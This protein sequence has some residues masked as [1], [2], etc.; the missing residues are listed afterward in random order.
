M[1]IAD[2]LITVAE[3]VPKVYDA[4]KKAEYDAF[5][6]AYQQ[7]G[8]RTD[9][10]R[11]FCGS[12]WTAETLKPKYDINPT[13]G[14]GTAIF[15]GC[16]FVGN[17][18]KH[19]ETL[20]IKLDFSRLVTLSQAFYQAYYITEL[21]DIDISNCI[22][23]CAYLF[24]QC[25]ALTSVKIIIS[26]NVAINTNS[27]TG[28]S[29]LKELRFDGT[30]GQSLDLHWSTKLSADS[31]ASIIGCLSP[32]ATNVTLTISET[33]RETFKAK[34][35]ADTWNAFLKAWSNWTIAYA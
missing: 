2:K 13:F 27:F 7:N 20:G 17:M 19:L 6:N 22:N 16:G 12:A 30:I 14:G 21:P 3:N 32:T 23:G 33:T 24:Y 5:W 11:C 26:E 8:N 18:K 9:Y 4:G 35:G 1:S 10:Q 29:E 25:A 31:M 15:Q 28:C 34:F